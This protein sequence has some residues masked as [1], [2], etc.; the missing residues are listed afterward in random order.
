M[1]L[2]T[3][4]D[5]DKVELLRRLQGRA[6]VTL[7]DESTT[8]YIVERLSRR[9][10]GPKAWILA[11]LTPDQEWAT[12]LLVHQE[13]LGGDEHALDVYYRY[14]TLPGPELYQD[15]VDEETGT[16]LWVYRQKVLRTATRPTIGHWKSGRLII[17]WDYEPLSAHHGT[18]VTV[19]F[20]DGT[21]PSSG[22]NSTA[23][24]TMLA[25]LSRTERES[26]GYQL[27]GV[28][29]AVL[30]TWT[31]PP[32]PFHYQGPYA[33]SNVGIGGLSEGYH[34]TAPKTASWPAIITTTY[35]LGA[36]PTPAEVFTV[37]TP[38]KASRIYPIGDNTVH[39][40]LYA[41]ETQGGDTLIIEQ[42]PAS[43][44]PLADYDPEATKIIRYEDR[45]WRGPI[46]RQVLVEIDPSP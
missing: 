18:L 7:A 6:H 36:D 30:S 45:K 3:Y 29:E 38:G 39:G 10:C 15:G 1:A 19:V 43:V 37:E 44:P 13:L 35:T 41:F 42:I 33:G 21:G 31:I 9:T 32:A 24:A 23:A 46:W 8:H 26:M 34:Y 2:T 40:A 27:P 25:G 17:D 12:A 4:L 20:G 28:F 5:A 22:A 16:G 11:A 14:E